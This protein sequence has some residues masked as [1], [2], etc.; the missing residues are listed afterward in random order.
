MPSSIQELF[1]EIPKR[2]DPAA[3][4]PENASLQFNITGDGGG[5]WHTTITDGKLTVEKG[6]LSQPSMTVTCT[7]QDMLAIVN[8]ELSAVSAFMQGR[9]KIEGDMA[10]AMKLQNL[11]A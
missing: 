10:L 11:L 3:W 7:A 1:A 8:N 5:Q 9:V 6:T 2:F 4:G